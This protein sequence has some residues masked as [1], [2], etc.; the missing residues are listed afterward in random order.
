MKNI[1]CIILISLASILALGCSKAPQEV[2]KDGSDKAIDAKSSEN[3]DQRMQVRLFLL[4]KKT[5]NPFMLS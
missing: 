4:Q 2:A 1:Q 5:N 3:H